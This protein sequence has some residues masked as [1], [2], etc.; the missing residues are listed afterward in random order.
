MFVDFV[1]FDP[2]G[3]NQVTQLGLDSPNHGDDF[4]DP[5]TG[6]ILGGKAR[7][8]L[9]QGF[10]IFYMGLFKLIDKVLVLTTS[11]FLELHFFDRLPEYCL[12]I[13]ECIG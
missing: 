7:D 5:L 11:W 10:L 3:L 13:R 1:D 2:E 6:E 8:N 12:V 4:I 9:P